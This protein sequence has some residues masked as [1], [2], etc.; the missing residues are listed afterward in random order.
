[1]T[2]CLVNQT[3]SDLIICQVCKKLIK[4]LVTFFEV[5]FDPEVDLTLIEPFPGHG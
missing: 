4:F 3:V 2:H 1:M 5:T